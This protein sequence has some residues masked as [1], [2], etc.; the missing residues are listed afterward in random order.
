MCGMADQLLLGTVLGL[1]HYFGE[2]INPKLEKYHSELISLSAGIFTAILFVDLLPA[3]ANDNLNFSLILAGFVIYHIIEKTV[4]MRHPLQFGKGELNL[5]GFF[6]TN[7]RNGLAIALLYVTDPRLAGLVMA[8]LIIA[9][10]ATSTLVASI[11]R[12][13]R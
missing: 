9:E 12:R 1:V 13:V 2:A 10:L 7:F 11:I 6:I 4:Y 5:A 3:A 8:P